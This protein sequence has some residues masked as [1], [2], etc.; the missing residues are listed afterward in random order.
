MDLFDVDLPLHAWSDEELQRFLY[1]ESISVSVGVGGLSVAEACSLEMDV[2]DTFL[3]MVSL[4]DAESLVGKMRR[5]ISHLR[6][7]CRKLALLKELGLV[8][9][10]LGQSLSSLSGG[11][12][13]ALELAAESGSRGTVYVLDEPTSGLHPCDVSRLLT[14][15]NRL[16]DGG[17]SVIFIE[18]NLVFLAAC[19]HLLD[20]GLAGGSAGGSLMATGRPDELA[21]NP[22]SVTGPY[23]RPLLGLQLQ[24]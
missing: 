7:L 1:T 15:L 23:L 16:V 19:D 8:Y 12:A 22:A 13:Q 10:P 14:I 3:A 18:H 24:H 21:L 2:F 17:N 6:E 20:L 9:L 5:I 11:E 4:E